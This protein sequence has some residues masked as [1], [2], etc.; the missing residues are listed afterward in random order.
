MLGVY[1]GSHRRSM[2]DTGLTLEQIEHGLQAF[3]KEKIVIDGDFIFLR[4]FIKN[5]CKVSSKVVECMREEFKN[6]DSDCIRNAIASDYPDNFLALQDTL[7]ENKN[8]LS[9]NGGYPISESEYPT[10]IQ[11]L[12]QEH[13]Q[14]LEPK[15][16]QV[17]E[18]GLS[19]GH[20]KSTRDTDIPNCPHQEIIKLYHEILPASPHVQVWNDSER[21]MLATRWKESK[22]RQNLSWWRGYFERVKASQFLSGRVTPTNGRRVFIA[23]LEW[24]VRPSNMAKVLNGQYD[25]YSARNVFQSAAA[26]GYDACINEF[27]EGFGG[28]DN[29]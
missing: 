26:K 23:S 20:G 10:D 18:Q 21:R 17:Q 12:E 9:E 11:E 1:K 22:D 27:A 13:K 15:Q 6:I 4:N 2:F 19:N 29:G 5:Q 8:T 28:E 25:D 14:E 3:G 16:E 24:L 7:S